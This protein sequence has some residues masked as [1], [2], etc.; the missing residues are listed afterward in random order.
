MEGSVR[1]AGAKVRIAA[2]LVDAGSGAGLW[3][4]T[5]EY[6]FTPDAVFE[7]VDDAVPR[8]VST[9]ADTQ[10]IMPHSMTES[11]RNRDPEQLSPYEAVLRSFG[12]FQRLNAAEHAAARS[13][14]ERAVQQP[15]DRGDCWAMLSMLYR[16]EY[17]HG[18][19]LRPDPIGRALAAARRAVDA[20]PTNHLG[21]HA[22]ASALFFRRELGAFRT[23]AERAIALNPMDGFTAA[24]LGFLIAYAGDW[25][26][27]CALA[28][29]STRLNP[30]HPGWYWFPLFFNAYRQRDYRRA[31]EIVLKVNMP[32]FWR[33]QFALAAAYG[34]LGE[35]ESARSAVQDLLTIRPDFAVT[36]RDELRKWWEPQLIEH[37]IEGLRK[38]GL[39]IAAEQGAPPPTHESQT[40]YRPS[41]A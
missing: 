25:E 30:H 33:T 28:E 15:P 27:G 3:A 40:T 22:L 19:N 2:Q 41:E 18:L 31:L 17:T 26:R 38:A 16:E 23:A 13:A 36:A 10:G 11:L 14:L 39:E 5:Y 35:K 6:P 32:A 8:I 12:H 1:K 7:L 20:A 21:Y 24:Y 37:L 34:Q 29:R 4:E 9:V